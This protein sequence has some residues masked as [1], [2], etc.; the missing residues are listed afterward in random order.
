MSEIEVVELAYGM[1]HDLGAPLRRIRRAAMRLP[2]GRGRVDILGAVEQ[3][4][5]LAEDLHTF[6]RSGNVK[7]SMGLIDLLDVVAMA[8]GILHDDFERVGG[9]V[10]TSELPTVLGLKG[11]LVRLFTN[12]LQN[13]IKYNMAGTPEVSISSQRHD[14]MLW[15]VIVR[16]NGIGIAERY[17]DAIFKPFR[18]L[19]AWH[20]YPGSG[21]GLNICRRVVEQHGGTIWVES[22]P[23]EGSSFCFTLPVM[24]GDT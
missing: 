14:D 10:F 17:H 18:R 8:T 7:N 9:K 24:E 2:S 16:D 22:M 19:W 3:I 20:E 15:C 21:L 13:A 11:E 23:G 4:E 5:L 1:A 6:S 12:L